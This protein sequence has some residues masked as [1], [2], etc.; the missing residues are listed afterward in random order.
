MFQD[1]LALEE[2]IGNVSTG[3]SEDNIQKCLKVAHYCSL[4]AT[5]TMISQDNEVKCSICQVSS[6][7]FGSDIVREYSPKHHSFWHTF[8]W[9]GTRT[10]GVFRWRQNW[11][12]RVWPWLPHWLYQAMANAEESVSHLQMLSLF[13]SIILVWNVSIT[14]WDVDKLYIG[15]LPI[16]EGKTWLLCQISHSYWNMWIYFENRSVAKCFWDFVQL[17]SNYYLSLGFWQF[18]KGFWGW[19]AFG[20][21]RLT[22]PI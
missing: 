3:L 13:S 12:T 20:E 1:L 15:T 4:D 7:G 6:I 8:S 11:Q 14:V 2:R 5:S 17:S 22:L 9:T 10:G 21:L 16:T 18:E 19:S